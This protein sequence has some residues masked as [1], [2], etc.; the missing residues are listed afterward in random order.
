MNRKKI[1]I[2]YFYS[3]L[4]ENKRE[5]SQFCRSLNKEKGD[6][7]INLVNV[8]DPENDDVTKHYSVNMV[9][10]MVFLTPKGEVA[11]RRCLPLSAKE[12]IE[13]VTERISKGE[14]P[15]RVTEQIRHKILNAFNSVTK[16]NDLTQL[17]VEQVTNDLQEADSELELY[18]MI[19]S[20][21]SAINHTI[22]DLQSFK[23]VLQKFS[24]K[25]TIFIV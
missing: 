5:L 13:D 14:L 1:E 4:Y 21:I 7:R 17:V 16:R 3:E 20:H 12:V 8:E 24:K 15:N 11:A 23:Q 9:P 25:Q 6:I 18:E 19:N 2:M 22:H 10:V